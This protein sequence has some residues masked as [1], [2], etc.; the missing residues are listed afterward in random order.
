MD[1]YTVIRRPVVSEKSHKLMTGY[2]EGAGEKRLNQYTFE[3]DTRATKTQIRAA[4]EA[5]FEVKVVSV[6]TMRVGGKQ[7]RV[8]AGPA[9]M[10]RQRRTVRAR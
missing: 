9:G 1:P 2:R 7:K 6:N 10:T 5:L 8:G 4:V 3:V